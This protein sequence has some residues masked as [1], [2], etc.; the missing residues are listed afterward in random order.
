MILPGEGRTIMTGKSQ[1]F[2]G[3]RVYGL[4]VMALG[5]LGLVC[6]TFDPGQTVP[7]DFPA[8]TILAYAA[9]ALMVAAA[10]AVEWR[11]TTA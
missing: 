1:S 6:G 8:H 4:G 7:K 9:A 10:L 2:V 11:R 3:A 5:V